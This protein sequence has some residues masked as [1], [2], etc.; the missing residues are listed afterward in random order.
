MKRGRVDQH[1]QGALVDDEALIAA[2]ASGE[3]AVQ[4]WIMSEE[5]RE[6][7]PLLD[8]GARAGRSSSRRIVA[9][10]R[11]RRAPLVRT[12]TNWRV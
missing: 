2:L 7:A 4:V 1:R 8:P 6:A 12:A 10:R 9:G 5:R 3:R 11:V